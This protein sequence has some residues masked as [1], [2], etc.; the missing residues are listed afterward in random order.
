MTYKQYLQLRLKLNSNCWHTST[1]E[2]KAK[3]LRAL[4]QNND[5]KTKKLLH[6]LLKDKNEFIVKM[7]NDILNT[8]VNE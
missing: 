1:I 7:A 2:E 3:I 5:V 6:F 8:K 4:K